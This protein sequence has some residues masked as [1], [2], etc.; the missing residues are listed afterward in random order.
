MG[1]YVPSIH[2]PTS[3]AD[4]QMKLPADEASCRGYHREPHYVSLV[5]RVKAVFGEFLAV[6]YAFLRSETLKLADEVE[7]RKPASRNMSVFGG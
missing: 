2:A 5:Y 3:N 6:V 7:R 1:A 4:L